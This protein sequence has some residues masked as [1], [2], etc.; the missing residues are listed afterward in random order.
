MKL[1]RIFYKTIGT[2]IVITNFFIVSAFIQIALPFSKFKKRRVITKVSAFHSKLM[3]KILG[4]HLTLKGDVPKEGVMIIG[5]HMSYLDILIYLSF[6]EALFITSVDMR[7]R[8]FLGQV[9]QMGGCLFVERRNPRG[10]PK[11][12]RAI[13]EFFTKGFSV[14]IFPEGTSSDGSTVLPFKNS[15]FQIPLETGC[16]VQ[17]IALKY[18]KIDGKAFGPETC[19]YVC[20]YG[21]LGFF[22][23]LMGLFTLKKVEASLTV[24]PKIDSTDFN[25]RKE[26]S[27][28][29]HNVLKEKYHSD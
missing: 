16:A 25:N 11:E 26:L 3:L 29:A 23:H 21:D 20:W 1:L 24:L 15:M 2:F 13:K 7:E 6:F 8:L 4:F 5:N 17:P 18:S 28:H 22:P 14:C 27:N 12:M 10:L 9:T 19:D